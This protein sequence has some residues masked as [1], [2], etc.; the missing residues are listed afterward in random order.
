MWILRGKKRK[1]IL[2]CFAFS[3][4]KIGLIRYNLSFKFFAICLVHGFVIHH[5]PYSPETWRALLFLFFVAFLFL[6]TNSIMKE[7]CLNCKEWEVA[8][9]VTHTYIQMHTY[10]CHIWECAHSS[11]IKWAHSVHSSWHT[12]T[13]TPQYDIKIGPEHMVG[14]KK[15]TRGATW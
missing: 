13:Y 10:A 7:T 12:P 6:V 15:S 14:R 5:D 1:K 2:L 9:W 3:P 4:A 8:I 11:H